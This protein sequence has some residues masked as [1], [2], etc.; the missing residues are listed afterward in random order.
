MHNRGSQFGRL[1]IIELVVEKHVGSQL[2]ENARFFNATQEER[3][4]HLHTPLL[5]TPHGSFVSWRITRS[6]ETHPHS[7]HIIKIFYSFVI[8]N[9]LDSIDSSKK[10]FQRTF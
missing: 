7:T 6:H 8:L 9:F 2:V 5:Q 10:T 4:I 3:V 1:K